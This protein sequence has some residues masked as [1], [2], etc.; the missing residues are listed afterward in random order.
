[1]LMSC[2]SVKSAPV[3][4]ETSTE[5]LLYGRLHQLDRLDLKKF[6]NNVFFVLDYIRSKCT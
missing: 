6:F 3:A 2:C 4:M 5:F 1:M